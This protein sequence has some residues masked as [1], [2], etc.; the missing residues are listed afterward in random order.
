MKCRPTDWPNALEMRLLVMA[1]FTVTV[2][3][4][5]DCA[6][7][8][9]GPC[10]LNVGRRRRDV[11]VRNVDF[12]SSA[13]NCGRRT[14]PTICRVPARR[15]AAQVFQSGSCASSS[16]RRREPRFLYTREERAPKASQYFGPMLHPASSTQHADMRMSF[17]HN[18][19]TP[20]INVDQ[21]ARI[22]AQPLGIFERG[23]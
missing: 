18:S 21:L 14:A 15:S 10:G 6:S 17:A 23:K 8:I 3:K 19:Q 5:C 12:F 11:L 20:D 7:R 4:Y 16:R 13:F 9:I 1:G 2:G 22:Q